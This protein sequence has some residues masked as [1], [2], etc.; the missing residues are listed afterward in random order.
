MPTKSWH[1]DVN[2]K[3]NVL[4]LHPDPDVVET[5]AELGRLLACLECTTCGG[6]GLCYEVAGA[7]GQV[8]IRDDRP[9]PE[10]GVS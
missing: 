9:C 4:A 7:D 10:C 3:L 5:G 8:I 2:N 1:H 6:E